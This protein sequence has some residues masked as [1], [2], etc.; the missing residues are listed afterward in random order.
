[1]PARHRALERQELNVRSVGLTDPSLSPGS[2]QFWS[3][4][5]GLN[6]PA[7]DHYRQAAVVYTQAC[8]DAQWLTLTEE[9]RSAMRSVVGHV[10]LDGVH[11]CMGAR[12]AKDRFLTARHCLY[13]YDDDQAKWVPRRIVRRQVALIGNAR[14]RFDATEIDCSAPQPDTSCSALSDNPV[15]ADHLVL[16]VAMRSRDVP[17]V[18]LPPMPALAIERPA[19]KQFM[20]VPGHSTWITGRGWSPADDVYVTTAAV[21]GCMVTEIANGCVVNS[22]QS[23]AGFSGAPM[24]ARRNVKELVMV[25]IFLGSAMEYEQCMRSDRNFGAVPPPHLLAGRP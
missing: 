12:I 23:E 8:L 6:K 9:Q 16:K 22:C 21:A 20:V 24:F 18:A 10:L 1:M 2:V 14:T 25:G 11:T 4:V 5:E 7:L 15:T 19:V 3:A 17:A 13:D